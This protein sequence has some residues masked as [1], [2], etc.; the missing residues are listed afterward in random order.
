MKRLFAFLL[1]LTMV[2][3]L[4]ACG[5]GEPAKD[6][7]PTVASTETTTEVPVAVST[8]PAPTEPPAQILASGVWTEDTG[9]CTIEFLGA[10]LFAD[11]DDEQSLRVW[12][13]FTNN[14][15]ETLSAWDYLAYDLDIQQGGEDLPQAF[16]PSDAEIPEEYNKKM[17]IRPGTT[18][19][20]VDQKKI[21]ADGGNVTVLLEADSDVSW[22]LD[23]N[24]LP[25]RPRSRWKQ[26]LFPIPPGPAHCLWK[27]TMKKFTISVS[28]PQK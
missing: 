16:C 3:S 4:A 2:L 6:Q 12:F 28:T 25:V 27:Q 5:G 14:T 10:E 8:E 18:I 17:N 23:L 9:N 21:T 11:D 26:P 19:R 1:T 24:D 7:T 20:C 22:E 13:D 15:S